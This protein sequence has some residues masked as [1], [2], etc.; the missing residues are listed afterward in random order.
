[1]FSQWALPNVLRATFIQGAMSILDSRVGNSW[2]G[3]TNKGQLI[4][5]CPLDILN[6]PKENNEKI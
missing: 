4:S 2:S 5:E 1:M 3:T 6:F